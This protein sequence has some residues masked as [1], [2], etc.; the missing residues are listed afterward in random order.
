MPASKITQIGNC[1]QIVSQIPYFQNKWIKA[2]YWI[3]IIT[4][5]FDIT[6]NLL[7]ISIVD[8]STHKASS[9]YNT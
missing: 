5:K 7:K 4:N 6:D 8:L 2:E 3:K 9:K 1:F